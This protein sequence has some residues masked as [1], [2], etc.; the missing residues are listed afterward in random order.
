MAIMKM[1]YEYPGS[2]F[3]I[4]FWAI[5]FF[6]VALVLLL[7]A[8]RFV[9]PQNIYTF[10]YDGSRFW[11]AFWIVFCF[12]IALLLLLLNGASLQTEDAQAVS[13]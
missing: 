13:V 10:Q 8:G 5:F 1:R 9:G 12:P 11:L 7:S 3:W 2:K 6:P 4:I